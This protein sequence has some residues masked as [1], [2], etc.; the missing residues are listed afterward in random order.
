MKILNISHLYPN[1]YDQQYA[2]AIHKQVNAI[3]ERGCKQKVISP[4]AWSPF[5]IKYLSS[6][7]KSY[8]Q[9]P[10]YGVIDG[11]DIFYPRS[12]FFPRAFLQPS[13]GVLTYFAI[14]KLV[15]QIYD[16]FRFDLIHA[17]MAYPDGYAGMLLC[18]ELNKPLILTFQATDVD[19]I[20]KESKICELLLCKVFNYAKEVISPS[21]RLANNL[22]FLYGTKSKIIGYGINKADISLE[23]I[24]NENRVILSASRLLTTKGID[25]NIKA[26][27]QLSRK[28][29]NLLL[30][31]VGDGPERSILEQLVQKLDLEKNVQFIGHVPHSS[32]MEFM[33][34]CD[35]FSMPSWQE[36]FGLVYIEAMAHGKPVVA[37]NGQGVDGIVIN[38]QTGMLTKPRDLNSLV[39]ALDFLLSHPEE[40]R[41]IGK[42]ARKLVLENYTW[43][44]N[45]EKT[46]DIYNEVLRSQY[47]L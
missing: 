15:S 22:N 36:T 28:Y 44:I 16:S 27:K 34:R 20:A 11:I 10:R 26:V 5:P 29:D 37:V 21:P 23:Q 31:I 41:N 18:K 39:A 25:L 42:R 9:L 12:T 33:A 24:K 19:I 40:A 4:V 8:S 2:I 13:Y 32:V 30:I 14:K 45:A 1:A 3:K 17:H 46:I 35:I 47:S 43:D 38:Q 7:W 6:K